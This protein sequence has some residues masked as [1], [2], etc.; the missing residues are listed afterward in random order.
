[1]NSEYPDHISQMHRLALAIRLC[2]KTHL[3]MTP[4]I[5]TFTTPWANSADDRQR[6]LFIF[7]KKKKKKK[8][9]KMIG[10]TKLCKLSPKERICM[11]CQNLFSMKYQSRFFFF[12]FFFF[13]GMKGQSNFFWEQ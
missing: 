1:M 11:K 3:L 6:F 9:K 4:L 7:P 5:L 2:S 10:S 12:F 13:F 8:K